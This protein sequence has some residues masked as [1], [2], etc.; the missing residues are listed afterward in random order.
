M[1]YHGAGRAHAYRS[2][3]AGAFTGLHP[4]ENPPPEPT[5]QRAG[6]A[7]QRVGRLVRQA[8]PGGLIEALSQ[9]GQPTAF[10]AP[11][12]P[13][14]KSP[15]RRDGPRIARAGRT[16]PGKAP[17]ATSACHRDRRPRQETRHRALVNDF[18]NTLDYPL[19]ARRKPGRPQTNREFPR[20]HCV[21]SA[22]C[23]YC[24]R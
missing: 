23:H 7:A 8:L 20:H 12:G 14:A 2:N 4:Q 21:A 15:A 16:P 5:E 10:R 9:R 17:R 19:P 3:A 6:S 13:P 22:R 18:T 1:R 24:A 11:D